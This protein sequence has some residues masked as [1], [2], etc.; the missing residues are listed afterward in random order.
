M[1]SGNRGCLPT[2][3]SPAGCDTS[4]RSTASPSGSGWSNRTN[5]RPL[6]LRETESR[7]VATRPG[8]ASSPG[9]IWHSEPPVM[10]HPWQTRSDSRPFVVVRHL[11]DLEFQFAVVRRDPF[12]RVPKLR[13]FATDLAPRFLH[14]IL[15]VRACPDTA[16]ALQRAC[17][18][19]W[20]TWRA[21]RSLT[22]APVRSAPPLTCTFSVV[23][24]GVDP[25]TSRFSEAR[26]RFSGHCS[27][28]RWTDECPAQR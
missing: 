20:G 17:R 14:Q 3:T 2:G 1:Q 21:R 13:T 16:R 19:G 23:G 11:A 27:R 22:P 15:G 12:G 9:R 25:V 4:S 5:G 26:R 6:P 10:A 8:S 28:P 18:R 24:T 7:H